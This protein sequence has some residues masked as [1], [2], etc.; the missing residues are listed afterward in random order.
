[1]PRTLPSYAWWRPLVALAVT[2]VGMVIGQTIVMV[3]AIG[4]EVATG[5]M[6]LT[7]Q[8]I[9]DWLDRTMVLDAARPGDLAVTLLL[10]AAI[11]PSVY[12]GYRVAGL[13][14]IGQVASIA[15]HLRWRWLLACGAVAAVTIAVQLGLGIGVGLASGEQIEPAWTPAPTLALSVLVILALV[16]LQA[17]AEEY[18]FRGLIVQAVGSWLPKRSWWTLALLALVSTLPFVFG[19]FYDAWGLADVGIFALAVLWLTLRTGGLEAAIALHVANNVGVFLLL[20][21]G[22]LGTTAQAESGG[23]LAGVLVTTITSIGYCWVVETMASRRGLAR[24]SPWPVK[25][26][27]RPLD[28]PMPTVPAPTMPTAPSASVYP[29]SG[30]L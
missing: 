7:D 4:I 19:H 30:A 14:P 24:F 18:A 12:L 2:G 8:A 25:G 22:A 13:R 15:F 11:I 29:W 17:A 28:V 20:A 10:L 23:S 5:S 21:S 16:P 27:S 6:T 26:S 9:W 3:I 1:M